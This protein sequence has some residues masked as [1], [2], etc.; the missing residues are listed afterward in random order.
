MDDCPA[1]GNDHRPGNLTSGYGGTAK[2]RYVKGNRSYG[3]L[4]HLCRGGGAERLARRG[5]GGFAGG[6]W[7][8]IATGKC[9]EDGCGGQSRGT[10]AS[11]TGPGVSSFASTA[12]EPASTAAQFDFANI[13][14]VRNVLN[15]SRSGCRSDEKRGGAFRDEFWP[16]RQSPKHGQRHQNL[17]KNEEGRIRDLRSGSRYAGDGRGGSDV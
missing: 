10:R 2:D 11:G 13:R 1:V 5:E 3:V 9:S 8:Q 15:A 7:T 4:G 14:K 6:G 16:K 12:D 17:L